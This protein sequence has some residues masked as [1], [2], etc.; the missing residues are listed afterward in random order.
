MAAKFGVNITVSAEAARPISV[1]STTPIGIA[2]Y[3]E[4][5]QNGLHFFMTTDK[6]IDAI[7]TIYKEK[8]GKSESFKQGS[9][10][11][12]LKAIADQ[13]VQTQIILSVFA[14]TDNN[15]DSDDITACKAAIEV[16]K[17]AKSATGY[18]PNL[19]IAPEFSGEDAIKS[20]LETMATRLKATGIVD[21]KASSA[22]EA[23]T[24]M[25]SFGTSRLLA[26]YPYVKTWDDETN[27]YAMT[28]QSAR[29]AGMIAYVDGLSEF[30]YSDSYSN[31]VMGGI[32]GTAIDVDF[33]MGETC[34]AD[35]LRAA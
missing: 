16:F 12:A 4:V 33:E 9:I 10:Y 17:N 19:L 29:I 21:L 5:L 6:A 25:G 15:D 27:D 2:G 22:S 32:S 26:A 34:T 1:E 23:I 8:K 28:P 35:E 31:R 7:E 14:R 13:A 24:K 3:E 18:R 11:R 20:A 30:G